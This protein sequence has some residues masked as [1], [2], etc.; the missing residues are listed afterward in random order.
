MRQDGTTAFDRD[1]PDLIAAVR[2][3]RPGGVDAVF[4]PVGGASLDRSYQLLAPGGTL[5][6]L[7]VASAVQGSGSPKLKLAGTLVRLLRLKLRPGSRRVRL[8]VAPRSKKKHPDQ[9]RK[10][11]AILLDWLKEGRID[12]VIDRVL[13]LGEARRAQELLEGSNVFGKIVLQP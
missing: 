11:V 13:P 5:V 9:F 1:D 6:M 12:P 3:R 7:G 10:D 2:A 8:F 4:D